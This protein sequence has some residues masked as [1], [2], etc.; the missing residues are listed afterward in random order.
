MPHWNPTIK[1]S[2]YGLTA[3]NTKED[4]ITAA[5]KSIAYQLKDIL[6]LLKSEGLVVEGLSIDGGMTVNKTFCQLLS[7]LLEEQVNVSENPESTAIGAASVA[8]VGVG[9]LSS[10]DDLKKVSSVGATFNPKGSL[11]QEDHSNWQK[12]LDLLKANY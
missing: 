1:G 11:D 2:F 7:D 3:D 10:I 4:L 12:N 5:F 8:M 9:L 6:K